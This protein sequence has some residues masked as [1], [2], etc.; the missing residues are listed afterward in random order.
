HQD[1]YLMLEISGK[2][3]REIGEQAILADL[4]TTASV[5]MKALRDGGYRPGAGGA[6]EIPGSAAH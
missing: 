5:W 4:K 2:R 1:V 3:G 6:W